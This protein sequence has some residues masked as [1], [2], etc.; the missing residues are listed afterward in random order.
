MIEGS[1]PAQRGNTAPA[2]DIPPSLRVQ[3]TRC[4]SFG[5]RESDTPAFHYFGV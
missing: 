2:K 1:G 3:I 4:Q 5:G